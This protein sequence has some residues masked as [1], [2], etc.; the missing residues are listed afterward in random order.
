[1]TEFLQLDYSKCA[2]RPLDSAGYVG[3]FVEKITIV[4]KAT[5]VPD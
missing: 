4:S 3:R 1:M 2:A 5:K